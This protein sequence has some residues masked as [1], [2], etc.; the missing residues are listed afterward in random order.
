MHETS[1]LYKKLFAEPHR[2]ETRVAIGDVGVLI[3]ERGETITFGGIR[4]LVARSGA[5][6]GYGENILMMTKKV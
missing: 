2:V 5:D 6:A 4:I 3:S 1:A